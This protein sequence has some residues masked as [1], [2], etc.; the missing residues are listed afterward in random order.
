MSP[1]QVFDTKIAVMLRHDLA[2]WQKLNVTSF[3]VSGIAATQDDIVGK[4]YV[5]ADGTTYLPMF[6]QPVLV[7]ASDEATL[8]TAHEKALQRQMAMSVFTEDLFKT[9]ND[10]DNREAV[11]AVNGDRDS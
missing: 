8:K 11:G 5:D 4:P 7:F 3:L 9:G 2:V 1:T 10:D 6:R